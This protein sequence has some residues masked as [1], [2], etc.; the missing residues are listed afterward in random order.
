MF[1]M[2]FF[3]YLAA[4]KPVVSVNLKA[5]QDFSNV[6]SIAHTADQF[7]SAIDEALVGNGPSLQKRLETAK[8]YTYEART[9]KMLSIIKKEI[10]A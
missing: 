4:G 2:K 6:V 8:L 5:I 1:P 9:K 10:S 7:I 3:E